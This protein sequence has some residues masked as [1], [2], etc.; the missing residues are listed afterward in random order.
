MGIPDFYLY[1]TD[2]LLPS[3]QM[4]ARNGIC[5]KINTQKAGTLDFSGV[6]AFFVTMVLLV[7]SSAAIYAGLR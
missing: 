1:D 6:P 4:L 5:G 2:F 3:S 7:Q